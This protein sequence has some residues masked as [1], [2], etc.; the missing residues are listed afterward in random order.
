M[1]GGFIAFLRLNIE[2]YPDPVPPLVDIVTQNPG[3]RASCEARNATTEPTSS[4]WPIR[5]KDLRILKISGEL[6]FSVV[7]VERAELG[8]ADVHCFCQ[9]GLEYRLQLAGRPG[10]DLQNLRGR[11]LLL[12]R[13]GESLPG[14]SEFAGPD[15]ELPVSQ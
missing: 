3:Q 5:Y 12:Q 2:A 14:L 15:F 10:D 11:S 8:L 1:I 7:Q 13:L 4:G 9:H 6:V